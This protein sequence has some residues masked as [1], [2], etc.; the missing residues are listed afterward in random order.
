MFDKTSVSPQKRIIVAYIL[1]TV[2]T[3]A[4][5]WQVH[6]YEFINLDDHYYVQDNVY[7]QSGITVDGLISVF[8]TTYVDSWFP[9]TW[10][11]LMFDYQFYGLNAGGYHVTN[12]ILHILST[13]L[14]FWFLNR[15]T[16]ELWKSA[17]VAA[18]FALHPLHVET[19]VWINKRKDVLS[20]FFWMLTLCLYVYYTEK[21]VVKRYIFVFLSFACALMSKPMTVTLPVVMILLDYWPL[22]RFASNKENLWLWQLKEKTPLL[23][24]SALFSMITI[25]AKFSPSVK[26]IQY[27]LYSRLANAPVS[28]ITYLGKTFWPND[29]AVFYPFSDQLPAWQVAGST[30][31]IIVIS[32]IV[33]TTA[34]RLPYLLIGWLWY[35]ITVAPVIGIIQISPRASSDNYTYLP[36][37]GISI[38]LAWGIPV[39]FLCEDLRK[40]ILFPAGIV[41][42]AVLTTL[43]WKQSGYWKNSIELWNHTIQITR[44]NYF[45]HNWIAVALAEKGK[46]AESINH[47][48]MSIFI[49]PNYADAYYNRAVTYAKVGQY[50][51]AINDYNQAIRLDSNYADA[52]NNRGT[53][54]DKL[55]QYRQAIADYNEVIRIKP[56]HVLAYNN[57]GATYDKLGQYQLAISEYSEAIR[58]NPKDVKTY[59]NRGLA[60]GK[61]RQ[62]QQAVADFNEA[63]R[64]KPDYTDAYYNRAYAYLLQGNNVQGCMDAQKACE[65][66]H[67]KVLEFAASK[68]L[69]R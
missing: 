63:I 29:L 17:F 67:C 58:I 23:I 38:M 48:N 7:V 45:A 22:R 5:F 66:D 24:L 27:P 36:L 54:F 31:L 26:S 25:Y 46:I 14:L 8:S 6:Q 16:G 19:V 1:L 20:A 68:G 56:D 65:L 41:L 43:T 61:L 3:L 4:V 57:K 53:V 69:C 64:L 11:S 40:K 33:I 37:I 49:K 59:N 62:Y 13:L 39:L 32:I 50:Q 42:I 47:S 21:P 15:M 18:F 9:M 10:L 55:G 51:Q 34:R 60:Y 35:A 30:L 28:F 44:N 52:Y 2:V 12:L